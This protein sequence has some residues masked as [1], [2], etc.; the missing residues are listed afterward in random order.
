MRVLLVAIEK[1]LWAIETT[2]REAGG[3]GGVPGSAEQIF[4]S[5]SR[6]QCITTDPG[7][8]GRIFCGTSADGLWRSDDWGRTWARV[9]ESVLRPR[10]TAV[11]VSPP[12]WV[13]G[14]P[15]MVSGDAGSGGEEGGGSVAGRGDGVVYAGT[16]PTRLFRS[17][18]GGESWEECRSLLA[19][20]SAPTWSFPP[21]PETSHVRWIAPDPLVPGRLFVAIEA[22]ALVT[23]TDRGETWAD[24]RPGGPYD[25]H[26]LVVHPR[27]PE[28]LYSAAGDGYFES[29]DGGV[30]W[31]RREEGLEH[32]YVWGLAVNPAD[33]EAVVVSAAR[34][35]GAAHGRMQAESLIYHRSRGEP[36]RAARSGLPD[37]SGTTIGA[38]IADASAPGVVYAAN[39]RGI[40]RSEDQGESWERLDLDWPQGLEHERVA[41][42]ALL[43]R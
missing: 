28:R 27:Q 3:E 20:P 13:H 6:L 15:G 30:T 21:R 1:S 16:E 29:R 36:W 42:V 35:A 34:S 9:G 4:R 31:E 25:T 43:G 7:R 19:L 5:E 12:A 10:V 37:P 14:T 39:N 11:A 23:S 32:R 24:R 40:F 18:D 8:P 22:G 38:L 26:T 33:P 17:A 41:G 2:L